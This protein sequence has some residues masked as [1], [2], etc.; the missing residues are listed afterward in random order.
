[1]SALTNALA[2]AAAS[3]KRSMWWRCESANLNAGHQ[4]LRTISR[5]VC[6]RR[7][8]TP[9]ELTLYPTLAP[10]VCGALSLGRPF[11]L[12]DSVQTLVDDDLNQ[13][14]FDNDGHLV[15]L[16]RERANGGQP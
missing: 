5:V 2:S 8:S 1:V 11:L 12:D 9:V 6:K 13:V 14:D 15:P 7:V 16:T 3:R 10:H 4:E